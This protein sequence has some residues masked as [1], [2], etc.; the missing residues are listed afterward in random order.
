MGSP[1]SPAAQL[2][3]G[4]LGSGCVT[5]VVAS[6]RVRVV[7]RRRGFTLRPEQG[8]R[9][10]RDVPRVDAAPSGPPDPFL[11]SPPRHASPGTP[12]SSR[13]AGSDSP[14]LS[15]SSPGLIPSQARAPSTFGGTRWHR[16]P[17]SP[18]RGRTRRA[19]GEGGG[20]PNSVPRPGASCR[21]GWGASG[22]PA[23]RP[24][25]GCSGAHSDAWGLV[26][27]GPAPGCPA[28]DAAGP[29]PGS[30]QDARCPAV[31]LS[32]RDKTRND[33]RCFKQKGLNVGTRCL[34]H[35]GGAGGAGSRLG[36]E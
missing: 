14:A 7:C 12:C 17:W 24:A 35:V 31:G 30:S 23:S 25:R 26:E 34:Q 21:R 22:P 15:L 20:P 32:T 10:D 11:G 9:W 8:S 2:F 13:A 16:L 27:S 3:P 4:L 19:L 28:G 18:R 5:W 29:A 36:L 6:P 33:S 1:A